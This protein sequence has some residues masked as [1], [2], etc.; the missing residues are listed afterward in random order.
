MGRFKLRVAWLKAGVEGF[1]GA[2]CCGGVSG[3]VG[4]RHSAV[5][6][7]QSESFARRLRIGLVAVRGAFRGLEARAR[8]RYAAT[9]PKGRRAHATMFRI[10]LVAAGRNLPSPVSRLQSA[11]CRSMAH[12]FDDATERFARLPSRP[13]S[14]FAPHQRDV[15]RCHSGPSSPTA[16]R[17]T[18]RSAARNFAVS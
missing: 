5:G 7:R 12:R 3:C 17:T 11:V 1:R 16:L 15:D 2:V 14:E 6:S 13:R 4:R 18:S 9:R 10:C 8:R